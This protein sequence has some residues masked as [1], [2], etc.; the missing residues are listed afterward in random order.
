[1]DPMFPPKRI[2]SSHQR[3]Q[4]ASG[5]LARSKI[6]P[7]P[8]L[9]WPSLWWHLLTKGVTVIESEISHG[10]VSP[11][12]ATLKKIWTLAQIWPESCQKDHIRPTPKIGDPFSRF[13]TFSWWTMS[14]PSLGPS[15]Q[16]TEP[17]E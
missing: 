2:S 14:G 13:R 10:L 4:P 7:F 12:G 1:M 15:V 16:A 11:A 17:I 6:Q 5:T 9:S 8:I 3:S